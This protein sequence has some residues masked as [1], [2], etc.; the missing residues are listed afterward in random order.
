[1]HVLSYVIVLCLSQAWPQQK[2][3]KGLE[4][5]RFLLHLELDPVRPP[6]WSHGY[7]IANKSGQFIGL[8]QALCSYAYCRSLI[9][10]NFPLQAQE[11]GQ[12][13]VMFDSMSPGV[14][15][16]RWVEEAR[17]AATPSPLTLR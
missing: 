5:L 16:P 8:A 12:K 15:P 9:A 17:Q 11:S 13:V 14:L 10:Q 3:P 4:A 2:V 6:S 1:M 7:A